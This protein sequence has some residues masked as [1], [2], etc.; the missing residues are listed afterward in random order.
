[1][2]IIKRNKREIMRDEM[3][4][5]D[6]IMAILNKENKTIMEIADELGFPGHEVVCWMMGMRRYG[7]IEEVGRPDIDG[8]FKYMIKVE[9]E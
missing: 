6:K 8:Y 4:M 5:T 2:S 1:M 9:E 3:I 7:S